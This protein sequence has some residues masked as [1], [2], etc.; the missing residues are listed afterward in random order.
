MAEKYTFESAMT[1]LNEISLLLGQDSVSL[2]EAVELYAEAAKLI[3][4]CNKKLTT[5]QTKLEKV[6]GTPAMEGV[7][8]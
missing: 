2:D 3:S 1:R 6:M 5:A 7:Q 4:F 8:D